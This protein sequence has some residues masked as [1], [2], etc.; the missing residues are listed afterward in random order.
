MNRTGFFVGRRF[1]LR[2]LFRLA[3]EES[4][5]AAVEFSLILPIM[6][7]LW[8]GGVEV[9]GALSV[10]RRVSAFASSMGDLVARSKTISYAQVNDIFDLSE[11][12]M[13]PYSDTGMSM[14]I[15]AVDLDDD[16]NAK[17]A[18]SRA[19]GTGLPAYSKTT[20]VNSSVPAALR[21]AG[22]GVSQLIMAETEKDYR[23]AV[24][25][26]IVKSLGEITLD[27]RMFFVPRL[28]NQVK[29]CPTDAASCVATI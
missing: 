15:T 1:S 16:G 29:I 10:D 8:I 11:A 24:G 12:A 28:T 7:T 5:V 19:R 27:G 13:F 25:Y 26:L 18:W 17:V 23:P 6:I 14:R 3:C 9:T 22:A 21:P 2:R 20:D 4:G